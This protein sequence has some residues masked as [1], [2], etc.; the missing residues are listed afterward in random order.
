MVRSFEQL[1]VRSRRRGAERASGDALEGDPHRLRRQSVQD[2]PRRCGVKVVAEQ[3]RGD[4]SWEDELAASTA[5]RAQA[6]P[7]QDRRD[8]VDDSPAL[9]RDGARDE[10]HVAN[11]GAEEVGDRRG[12]D[13]GDRV[14]DEHDLVISVAVDVVDDGGGEVADAQRGDVAGVAR[15]TR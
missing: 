9:G 15:S 14:P 7:A 6:E 4:S 8:R 13:A 3:V 1:D 5:D 12:G 2:Q 10:H 11:A